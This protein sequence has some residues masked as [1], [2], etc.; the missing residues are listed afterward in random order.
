MRGRTTVSVFLSLLCVFSCATRKQL[1]VDE[2]PEWVVH[3]PIV[4]NTFV[5]VGHAKKTGSTTE[6]INKARK[7]AMH[8]L[9]QEVAVKISSRSVLYK[10][11]NEAGVSEYYQDRI[12]TESQDYLEGFE[13]VKAF[14]TETDYWVMYRIDRNLYYKKKEERRQKAFNFAYS[15]FIESQQELNNQ[16][17]AKAF[18]KQIKGLETIRTYLGEEAIFNS[19]GKSIHLADEIIKQIQNS[20]QSLRWKTPAKPVKM[21]RGEYAELSD[22]VMLENSMGAPQQGWPVRVDAQGL[23]VNRQLHFT[24]ETGNPEL[25]MSLQSGRE[26]EEVKVK[27]DWEHFVRMHTKDL[28]VRKLLSSQEVPES[29]FSFVIQQPELVFV[30]KGEEEREALLSLLRRYAGE[31]KLKTKEN[32]NSRE[33]FVLTCEASVAEKGEQVGLQITYSLSQK[34]KVLYKEQFRK[35]FEKVFLPRDYQFANLWKKA[36]GEFK[37]K[38]LSPLIDRFIL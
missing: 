20:L 14:E 17:Y 10:F 13:P 23:K 3:K 8:N 38:H 7:E 35:N 12:K 27:L 28:I 9:T 1:P 26:N 24:N 15:L 11:E 19:E 4:P 25:K 6:Y 18:Q 34:R 32:T 21:K 16:A 29:F 36:K 37:R 2:L 5:G 33:D 30:V 31:R 22:Y